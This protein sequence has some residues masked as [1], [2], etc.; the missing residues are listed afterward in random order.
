MVAIGLRVGAC[1]SFGGIS[2]RCWPQFGFYAE[3]AYS[4]YE[5]PS[6]VTMLSAF[7]KLTGAD[8]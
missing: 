7:N 8:V 2:R 5:P 4:F 6:N 3:P 1:V